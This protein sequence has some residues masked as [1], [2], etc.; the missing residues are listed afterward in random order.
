VPGLSWKNQ[1]SRA[2]DDVGC[3]HHDD[4]AKH[5]TADHDRGQHQGVGVSGAWVAEPVD[6]QRRG[7]VGQWPMASAKITPSA[8][9]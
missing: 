8:P 7:G 6:D 5:L 4:I 3:L 1:P 2:L 9:V